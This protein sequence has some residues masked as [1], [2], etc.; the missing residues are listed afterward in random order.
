ML[1][2]NRGIL[3]RMSVIGDA[4]RKSHFAVGRS[5]LTLNGHGLNLSKFIAPS[6]FWPLSGD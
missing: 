2:A 5:A 6:S 1:D 3:P 4:K